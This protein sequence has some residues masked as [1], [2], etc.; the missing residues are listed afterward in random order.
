[1]A[2]SCM[3]AGILTVLADGIINHKSVYTDNPC[4]LIQNK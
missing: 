4:L 1:M 3:K 2:A